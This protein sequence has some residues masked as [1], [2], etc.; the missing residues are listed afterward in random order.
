MRGLYN[1]KCITMSA[2][3]SIHLSAS[4][5]FLVFHLMPR[6]CTYPYTIPPI[7]DGGCV[8]S[9][10]SL[11]LLTAL[12]QSMIVPTEAVTVQ[13]ACSSWSILEL[14][15]VEDHWVQGPLETL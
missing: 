10:H 7:F 12:S 8:Q 14:S 11:C 5:F 4:Q 6:C 13:K 15:P 3:T 1:S 9:F 2:F